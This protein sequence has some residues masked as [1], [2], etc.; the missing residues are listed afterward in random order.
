MTELTPDPLQD[1]SGPDWCR[2]VGDAALDGF[3][4][5]LSGRGNGPFDLNQLRQIAQGF[6]ADHAVMAERYRSLFQA[7]GWSRRGSDVPDRRSA[8]L[9]RLLVERFQHLLA[10]A[11][12][13]L[14]TLA[15]GSAAI[16]RAAI[17][18][19]LAAFATMTPGNLWDQAR[20]RCVDIVADLRMRLGSDFTWQ[21][22]EVHPEVMKLVDDVRMSVLPYFDNFAK[23][24]RWFVTVVDRHQADHYGPDSSGMP[25]VHKTLLDEERFDRLF[26]AVYRD[27]AER[28]CDD[29][30]RTQ[31]GKRY[32]EHAIV[33][34][35]HLLEHL[36]LKN[37][38][39]PA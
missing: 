30:A 19:I 28:L 6:K 32:D 3:L 16:P 33:A 10:P 9:Q 13:E 22:A 8:P 34:L 23:R 20:R 35:A 29:A 12:S 39:V 18:G 5:F 7:G 1:I 31:L 2:Q 26:G 4:A 25:V 15:D 11:G 24:R 37:T 38:P 21:R 17:P 36:P 27:L 14:E